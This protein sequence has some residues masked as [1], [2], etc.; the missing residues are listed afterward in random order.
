MLYILLSADYELFTWKNCLVE[1]DVLI[2]P[3]HKLLALCS[4]HQAPMTLFYDYLCMKWY[5]D[6]GLEDFPNLVETQLIEYV[7]NGHD[8]Q[9]HIHPHWPYTEKKGP[10]FHFPLSSFL[11]G[12]QV[13]NESECYHLAR[14]YLKEVKD[15]LED[16]LTPHNPYYQTLAYR[17]GGYGIQ[18]YDTAIYKA[19]LDTGYEIDSSVVPG[20]YLQN[21]ANRIDFR[22]FSKFNHCIYENEGKKLHEIPIASASLSLI[23]KLA[24]YLDYPGVITHHLKSYLGKLAVEP[25]RG[26]PI[27]SSQASSSTFVSK[28]W[29]KLA[30]P[31]KADW[32]FLE[33]SRSSRLMKSIT[34]N[35]LKDHPQN[36]DLFFSFSCHPKSLYQ[37]H[38]IA[39]DEYLSWVKSHF[40]DSVRFITYPEAA[41]IL[42]Q[43][44]QESFTC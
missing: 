22:A 39:L 33:A 8:V 36:K 9:T 35:Y 24:L 5:R 38:F 7:K 20:L 31:L 15:Y 13:E 21:H 43:Q 18:P 32:M 4:K 29:Q 19:L 16:L 6:Q 25:L 28:L 11:L 23:Q 14:S 40:S 41:K 1:Q 10:F 42:N 2:R 3:S 34:L 44:P 30:R 37:D 17:A 12:S 26:L 27:Q